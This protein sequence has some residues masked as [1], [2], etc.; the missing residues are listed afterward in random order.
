MPET[1]C[2]SATVLSSYIPAGPPPGVVPSALE[3]GY[4][5]LFHGIANGG[6]FIAIAW[7]RMLS[8]VFGSCSA[9]PDLAGRE[10]DDDSTPAAMTPTDHVAGELGRR[11]WRL[12]GQRAVV[13]GG[14][15]AGRPGLQESQ[16]AAC[17]AV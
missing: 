2:R 13:T 11:I 4:S 8:R 12:V 17:L 7:P 5:F 9:R 6:Q 15:A 1:I 16:S 14:R 3:S 10:H